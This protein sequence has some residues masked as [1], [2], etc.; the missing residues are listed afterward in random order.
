MDKQNELYKF[1][2]ELVEEKKWST[3]NYQ[4][5]LAKGMLMIESRDG[6]IRLTLDLRVK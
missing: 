2:H 1:Y 6:K 3:K 4:I 5:S